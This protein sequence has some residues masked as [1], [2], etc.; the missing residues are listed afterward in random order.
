MEK[1][2]LIDDA[3]LSL[4]GCCPDKRWCRRAGLSPVAV[5]RATV[6]STE[7]G[8]F[9]CVDVGGETLRYGLTERKAESLL[10]PATAWGRL[11]RLADVARDIR[12]R[13]VPCECH[14]NVRCT[15]AEYA[16]ALSR[17]TACGLSLSAYV[18]SLLC[19][20]EPRKALDGDEAALLGDLSYVARSM[21][22]WNESCIR[23]L[24]GVPL[25]E[26]GRYLRELFT[27]VE[28]GRE[29]IAKA[30]EAIDFIDEFRRSK[31]SG[32]R[33]GGAA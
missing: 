7:E 29:F 4:A 1:T 28:H 5:G 18:R 12:L 26:R 9:L 15:A 30:G 19:G 8:L 21:R 23:A 32:Q 3:S 22:A 13:T 17:A 31:L 33:K 27:S 6:E 14:L 2:V 10:R 25:A 11:R 20:G 16:R 24:R